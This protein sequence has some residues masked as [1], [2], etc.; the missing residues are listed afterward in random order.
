MARIEIY[1]QRRGWFRKRKEYRWRVR[2]SNG[3]ILAAST[4]GYFNLG[5][6]WHAV[7]ETVK[8]LSN[9]TMGPIHDS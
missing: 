9:A 6:L 7:R 8:A 1:E 5:D 4:E 2:S 3:R